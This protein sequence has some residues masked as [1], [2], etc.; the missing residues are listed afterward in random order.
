MAGMS[1][2]SVNWVRLLGG[3]VFLYAVLQGTA[4]ALNSPLGQSGVMVG[5]LVLLVAL[6]V[7][8]ILFS[9]SLRASWHR[10]GMDK[11]SLRGLLAAFAIS[12]IMIGG[13]AA[14]FQMVGYDSIRP[15]AAW[16]ALGI[17]AQAGI[18]EEVVFRGFLYGHIRRRHRFWRSAA[19]SAAPFALVHLTL[20]ATM[21]WKLAFAST[22]LSVWLSFP[23]AKLYDLGGGTI[24]APAIAQAVIQGVPK[25]VIADRYFPF[26]WIA[27]VMALMSLVLLIRPSGDSRS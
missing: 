9:Q 19:L 23:L 18:A 20:F 25:L 24:W 3:F 5:A 13:A 27:A 12:V 17:F 4:T 6:V 22:V 21:D 16:L 26:F 14:Y 2:E 1:F 7:R 10:L 15:N 8:S 11:P